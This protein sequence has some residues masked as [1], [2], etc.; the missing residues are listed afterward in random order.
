[1]ASA[2]PCATYAGP[3][4]R[5]ASRQRRRLRNP[6][7][8]QGLVD[9]PP[10]A[11]HGPRDLRGSQTLF[12]QGDDLRVIEGDRP[13]FVDAL[14][15]GGLDARALA[16]PDKPQLHLGHHAQ[17]RQ[18]H[19]AHRPACVDCGLKDPEVR[20]LLFQFVHEVEDVAGGAPQPVELDDDQRVARLRLGQS[21]EV[22]VVELDA[23]ALVGGVSRQLNLT[24][25]LRAAAMTT[26]RE[27]VAAA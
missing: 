3:A 26:W 16:V 11:A 19:A 7:R 22:V 1:M 6:R 25:V 9:V 4:L 5:F 23:P 8:F 24:A 10:L 15:L 17:H 13:A 2:S 21:D 14:G 18:D 27:A 20:S 12:P